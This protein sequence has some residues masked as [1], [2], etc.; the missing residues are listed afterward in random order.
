MMTLCL[1]F[2]SSCTPS[3][4]DGT[5][6]DDQVEAIDRAQQVEEQILDAAERQRRA[7]EENTQ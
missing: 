5:V 6:F 7:I 2:L 1:I 4:S 3:D